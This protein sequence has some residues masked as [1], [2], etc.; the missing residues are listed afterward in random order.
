MRTLII[1]AFIL[2]AG[3]S[4]ASHPILVCVPAVE[5]STMTSVMVCKAVEEANND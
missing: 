3:C 2:I 5:V 4:Q 1:I